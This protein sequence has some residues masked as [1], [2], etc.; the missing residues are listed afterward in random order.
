MMPDTEV[1]EDE[2]APTRRPSSRWA[3]LGGTLAL[4]YVLWYIGDLL[5]F[6]QRPSTYN[7]AHRTYD[8]PAMRVVF[9]LVLL[10]IVFHGLNGLRVAIV[11][12]R[13][14]LARRDA[15]LAALV[16]FLTFATWIPLTLLLWWP[17]I[18]DWLAR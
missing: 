17:S 18:K 7:A 6:S 3:R 4:A 2:E 16:R 13:P 1:L 8:S 11:D 9:A 5:L 14:S 12:L 10:G 15:V